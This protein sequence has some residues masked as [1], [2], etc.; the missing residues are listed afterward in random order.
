[1]KAILVEGVAGSGKTTYI[2]NDARDRWISGKVLMLTFSRTGRDVL[3]LYLEHRNV[4]HATV[5][6]I[7]G[8]ACQLLRQLG[9]NR[10]L[11]NRD[12]IQR[13][14][15]PILYEQVSDQIISYAQ[16][17]HQFIELPSPS[18]MLMQAL[19][20]DI[21]FYRASCAF[22]YDD[23]AALEE[24]LSGKLNHDW[25]LIRRLF[26]AYENYRETWHPALSNH[27]ND[28]FE[29]EDNIHSLPLG[30]QGFRSLGEAVY[31]LLSYI[32]DSDILEK[33]GQ[34][35]PQQFIDE[36]HDTTPLQLRFLLRLAKSAQY[37]VAVGDRFQNI[38]AW[39]GTNTDIVF[40]QF[41]HT[42][43]AEKRY[44]NH[45]YRYGQQIANL[46]QIIT[47]RPITS[48]TSNNSI[49]KQLNLYDFTH[50]D[51]ET[52]IISQ[53]FASQ[54]QAAFS[55]FT[56]SKQ[57]IALNINHSIGIAILNILC[58]LRYDYLLDPKSKVVKNIGWDFAQFLHLPHCL[59]PTTAKQEMLKKPSVQ[60]IRMYFDIHLSGINGN[61]STTYT[62]RSAYQQ[63]FYKTLLAWKSQYNREHESIYDIMCWFEKSAHLWA[64]NTQQVYNRIHRAAWNAL[65]EDALIHQY[66]LA[67]WPERANNLHKRW[68]SREGIR[69]VTISQAKGREYDKVV[70]YNANEKGFINQQ[71]ELA[72]HQFYVAITRV[73][74][75]LAL[76]YPTDRIYTPHTSTQNQLAYQE[77]VPPPHSSSNQE[78]IISNPQIPYMS[79]QKYRALQEL[80]RIKM[81]LKHR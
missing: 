42:L 15:L 49:V 12:I 75:H 25:R 43:N 63:E 32:E 76:Y 72:R 27:D 4:Q 54:I 62:T 61:E 40:E 20:D 44:L 35:Y 80:K 18:P 22:D 13:E 6:T 73:K 21:D 8:F 1:M 59:L 29:K 14:L 26:S 65:K 24:I 70:V 50:I 2:A 46:A 67:Q 66:T 34:Q 71:N 58:V 31:D 10:F 11:L 52:V 56:H 81:L 53:D 7:D 37:V 41:I 39:R 57:K 36:F 78:P 69:F 79:T 45:S 51:R 68:N 23:A 30:E 64:T 55:L 19:M 60:T 5:H 9:D 38:F 74:K 17:T 16:S 3:K 48:D 77:D 28:I 47:Q 33:I